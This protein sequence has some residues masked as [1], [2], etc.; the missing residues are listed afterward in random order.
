MGILNL[1]VSLA[2]GVWLW[3]SSA[4]AAVTF[5][6]ASSSAGA[7]TTSHS[8]TIAADANLV[9]VHVLLRDGGLSP[10]GAVSVTIGGQAASLISGCDAT[11]GANRVQLWGKTA[12]LTGAQTVAV[13]AS[14]G[15]IDYMATG[16]TSFK[17]AAQSGT[18]GTCVTDTTNP[19]TNV[20]INAIGS[21]VGEMGVMG[22]SDN[23]GTATS[24]APDAAT[25][26]STERFNLHSSSQMSGCGYTEDGASGTIDMRV[27]IST[28]TAAAGAAVS[29][30]A[31][32]TGRRAGS[33]ILF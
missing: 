5:D 1:I 8:H 32:T 18:F 4:I 16:V 23:V 3:A 10:S 24:C 14:G 21:A 22:V 25:P 7:D 15:T 6:A 27:D 11:A 30:R 29:I 19:G 9:V 2:L 31:D 33:P 17:G 13:D 28:S 20:D 26:T 12:P